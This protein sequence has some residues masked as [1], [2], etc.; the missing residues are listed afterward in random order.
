MN[1]IHFGLFLFLCSCGDEEL[2][3]DFSLNILTH[4]F[5]GDGFTEEDGDCNDNDELSYPEADELCDE[6]DNNCNGVVDED[7]LNVFY[8]DNDYDGYGNS[9]ETVLSCFVYYGISADPTDCDDNSNDGRNFNLNPSEN[10]DLDC[11]GILTVYDCY[12]LLVDGHLQVNEDSNN[13][14]DQDCDGVLNEAAGGD[15]CDD[16]YD[17]G[18]SLGSQSQDNDCD[19]YTTSLDCDDSDPES[20]TVYV[21]GDCDGALTSEDC[22][23]TTSDLGSYYFDNDCDGILSFSAFGDDCDDSSADFGSQTEDLDCDGILT[24]EDCNDSND[25]IG[26]W[27]NDYDCDGVVTSLDCDDL[28]LALGSYLNDNDCDGVL[29]EAAGGDDCNDA[30]DSYGSQ[31]QD[32]DCD[33]VLN[34]ED[35]DDEDPSIGAAPCSS[36]PF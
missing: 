26:N 12:E 28:D 36:F 11:D 29:N 16:S 22:D 2:K 31:Y 5:D 33:G 24:A 13:V 7:V 19:S 27:Q 35:C 9:D 6:L 17:T 32:S 10:Q 21:D 20:L 34:P 25:E 23:D 30:S 4:D 14:G 3:E 15:D 8:V 1:K 18:S